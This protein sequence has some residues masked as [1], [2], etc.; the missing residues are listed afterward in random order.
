MQPVVDQFAV[1]LILSTADPRRGEHTADLLHLLRAEVWRALIGWTPG[2]GYEPIEYLS[3]EVTEM[4]R[5]VTYY[6]L[7]FSAELTV[8]HYQG[9][10]DGREPETW[11]EYELAGLPVLE[12]LDAEVDVID[13][14]ADPNL[15]KPGPDGRVEFQLGVSE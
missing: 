3:G 1:V 2:A 8:G 7:L 11:Q 14:I 15:Q 12:A 4:D 9:T 6:T 10:G 13:P 5:S